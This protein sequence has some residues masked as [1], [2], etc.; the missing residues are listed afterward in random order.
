[1]EKYNK[2][3]IAAKALVAAVSGIAVAFLTALLP[4]IQDGEPVTAT[5]WVTATI[6]ALIAGG[7]VGGV[8]YATPN[9]EKV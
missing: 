2:I 5:G 3:L 7:A 1:M 4:Y 9:A 8:V 6:A